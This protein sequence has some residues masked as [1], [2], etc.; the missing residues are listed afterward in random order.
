[1]NT[2]PHIDFNKVQRAMDLLVQAESMMQISAELDIL[3]SAVGLPNYLVLD[4]A[5]VQPQ[6]R[7]ALHNLVDIDLGAVV[8][9][10]LAA[11][12]LVR[13]IPLAMNGELDV[14]DLR[15]GAAAS[16]PHGS[17][18][19]LLFMGRPV[20]PLAADSLVELLGIACL[21]ASHLLQAMVRLREDSCPLSPRELQC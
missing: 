18:T 8:Q 4:M 12:L 11:R 6:V 21:A 15:F 5:G 7:N 17:S 1:M 16:A 13:P 3:A 19:C 14:G 20:E 2:G 9:S 10:D